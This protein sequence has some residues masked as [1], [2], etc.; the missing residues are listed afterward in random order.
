MSP[1]VHTILR[2]IHIICGTGS[3]VL[4][5]IAAL[6]PKFGRKSRWHRLL[7][8]VY[9]VCMLVM[10]SLAVPLA[11]RN[12]DA[13]L[14]VIGLLT[15]S[16]V[17]T[18]WLAIRAVRNIRTAPTAARR[19]SLTITHINMMG[20][21]YISAWTAFFVANHPFGYHGPWL[22]IAYWFGPGMVGTPLII[23]A[24]RRYGERVHPPAH[25]KIASGE[26]FGEPVR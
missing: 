3:F 16:A 26:G 20:A 25:P 12:G 19:H 23:R 22:Q 18:G 10:A 21:S 14:F 5:G 7:G 4:G 6:L 1:E 13:L 17:G 8:R 2:L 24:A 9:A 11:W 15:L